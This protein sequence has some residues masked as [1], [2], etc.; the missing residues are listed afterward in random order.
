MPLA[1]R[2]GGRPR[3]LFPLP[4]V[5][6]GFSPPTPRGGAPGEKAEPGRSQPELGWF[7]GSESL[8]HPSQLCFGPAGPLP[9][10]AASQATSLSW[11]GTGLLTV[12]ATAPEPTGAD[13]EAAPTSVLP[14]GAGG[15]EWETVLLANLEPDFANR[16]NASD[17]PSEATP[18]PTT[19]RA[20]TSGAT[21]AWAPATLPPLGGVPPGRHTTSTPEGVGPRDPRP[22]VTEERG[23][24]GTERTAEPGTTTQFPRG[25]GSGEEVSARPRGLRASW[26]GR[27]VGGCPVA[28]W[29]T[30]PGAGT[31]VS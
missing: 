10:L 6:F 30:G 5:R 2:P 11:R 12:T 31:G 29:S 23:P 20:W 1:R 24:W 3:Q 7:G 25:E 21:A 22:A 27:G 9:D 15:R 19:H 17:P 4:G 16:E 28:W 26:D 13:P 8:P 14:V 18:P